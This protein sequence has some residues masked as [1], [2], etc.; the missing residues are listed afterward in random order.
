MVALCAFGLMDVQNEAPRVSVH[1]AE[2]EGLTIVPQREKG[3]R[4]GNTGQRMTG[5]VLEW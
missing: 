2:E 5:S 3:E 1:G 4:S